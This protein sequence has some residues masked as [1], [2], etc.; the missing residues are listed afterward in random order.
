MSI[1]IYSKSK[2]FKSNLRIQNKIKVKVLVKINLSQ[3]VSNKKGNLKV[4][5]LT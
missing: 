2:L 4:L 3:I 1:K 5:D